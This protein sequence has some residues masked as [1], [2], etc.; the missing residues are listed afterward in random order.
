MDQ[1]TDHMLSPAAAAKRAGCGRT[2][3]MRALDSK[4][5]HGTRDNRN[6]WKISRKDLDVWCENRT[7]TNR[8]VSV[9]DR[10]TDRNSPMDTYGALAR[11]AAAEAKITGLEARL[12]EAQADRDAWRA[13]AERLSE[14]RP[15]IIERLLGRRR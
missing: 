1:D 8:T 14:P 11:L 7:E 9:S 6:R 13:Q 2:S 12:H 10:D 3:I 15:S 5:L 4:D